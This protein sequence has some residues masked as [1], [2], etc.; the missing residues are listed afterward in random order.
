MLKLHIA[1]KW[2]YN[3]VWIISWFIILNAKNHRRAQTN[4]SRFNLYKTI[5]KL[6]STQKPETLWS[7]FWNI[8]SVVNSQKHKNNALRCW[9]ETV[10]WWKKISVHKVMYKKEK[11]NRKQHLTKLK[12]PD[13]TIKLQI[14]KLAK[15]KQ[16]YFTKWNYEIHM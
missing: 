3:N 2:S 7:F 6:L 13:E 10:G 11:I 16:F 12:I 4:L 9:K 1:I 14:S 15:R 5:N 8:I